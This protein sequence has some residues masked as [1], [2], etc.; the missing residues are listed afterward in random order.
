MSSFW[1]TAEGRRIRKEVR[2]AAD[3]NPP[4]RK[5]EHKPI[6]DWN[7]PDGR[8]VRAQVRAAADRSLRERGF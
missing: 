6:T 7:S 2:E 4:D 1:E 3:R 8:K 5:P